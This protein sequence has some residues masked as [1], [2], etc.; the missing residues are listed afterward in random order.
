MTF[1]RSSL[2]VRIRMCQFGVRSVCSSCLL[3][4]FFM[5][6]IGVAVFTLEKIRLQ[7]L[8]LCEQDNLTF[9]G[10]KLCHWIFISWNAFWYRDVLFYFPNC[11]IRRMTMLTFFDRLVASFHPIYFLWLWFNNTF[12][13]I[14]YI[15]IWQIVNKC[16]WKIWIDSWYFL[17]L[18]ISFAW[19]ILWTYY[20]LR[21]FY[22]SLRNLL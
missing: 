13:Y 21:W 12:L 19:A 9:L 2:T 22:W 17:H 1:C 8:H 7:P 16:V 10:P 15:F 14:V 6:C 18:D 3:C 20:V 4:P 11:I 5:K